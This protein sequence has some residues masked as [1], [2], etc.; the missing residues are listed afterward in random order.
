MKSN[1]RDFLKKGTLGVFAASLIPFQLKAN[2]SSVCDPTTTDILGPFFSEGAPQTS[3]IVP[4]DYEGERLFLTGKLSAIDCDT[5][6]VA[7][8]LDFWQ[9]DA[10][11]AYDNDGFKFRGKIIT[12]ENGNYNLE[13][14]IP[15]KYLNGSQYRPS[16]IHLKVQ[17][18]GY[19]DLVTQIY[20]EGDVDIPSDPW[21]SSASAINRIIPVNSG[22]AG[23]WFGTFDIVLS[24]TGPVGINEIQKEY[25]DLS[26]N[27]PN[28][29]NSSTR[30]FLVLNK[31]AQTLIEI[32]DQKGSLIKILMNQ[33]LAK[34]RYELN[35]TDASLSN[36]IYTTVWTSDNKLVKT[37][38]MIHQTN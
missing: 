4:E 7:A 19:D 36:G 22:F 14:I 18:E 37:I 6:I 34:G 24:G 13:T 35:W 38:K 26:Q 28:P 29:F 8:V 23:D 32:Y 1:R 9:A 16:H 11:G 21:A 15:G 2:N 17:A 33:D 27:Y 25:G 12:D 20:F 3:S 30:M 31:N 5:N 10:S